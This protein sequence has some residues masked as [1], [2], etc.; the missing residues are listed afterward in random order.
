MV[1]KE[2]IKQIRIAQTVISTAINPDTGNNIF[3][4]MRMSSF[5]PLNLP[6]SFGLMVTPPTPFNTILWQWIN[7]TY[8]AQCNYGNRNASSEYTVK[9]IWKSYVAACIASISVA[10]FTRMLVS[11]WT[12][13]MSGGLQ[14]IF[15]A[16]TA[17][18]A[19]STADFLNAFMM[20]VTEL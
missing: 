1:S 11:K 7:Q 10:L 17:Y 9:T 2:K 5:L 14:V 8:N 16:F 12:R 3:W 13:P 4:S 6:I 19:T 20:R 18:L 15:N